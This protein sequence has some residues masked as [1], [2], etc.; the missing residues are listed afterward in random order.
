MEV[1]LKMKFHQELNPKL[2]NNFE[3]KEEVKDKLEEITEAFIEYLDIPAESILDVQITG[4]SANYNYTEHSDLDLHLIVDYEKV[5]QE[6][7]IVEG[8]LWSMKSAFNKEHDISI[9][10]VPVEVYAEDS[11]QSAVSNGVYSLLNDEWIKKPEKIEPTT[12][13]AAVL[14]KYNEIKDIVDKLNDSEEAEEILNKVYEMRKAGLAQA[15]EFSTENL[16]FKMLRNEGYIDML[17]KIKKEKIDKQLTLESYNESVKSNKLKNEIENK[18]KQFFKNDKDALD[19]AVVEVT[20]HPDEIRVEV[21]VE[22]DYNGM[23]NLSDRLN[24]IVSKYDKYAYFDFDQ[25]G[26]MV[27]TIEKNNATNKWE[28]IK[29]DYNIGDK[30]TVNNKEGVID[31]LFKLQDDNSLLGVWIKFRDGVKYYT[32]K[33]LD[34]RKNES[35]KEDYEW[36][37]PIARVTFDN[38]EVMET[39]INGTDEE[40]KSYYIG[41]TF[42]LGTEKD[43]MHKVVNVE[44]IRESYKTIKQV[45]TI[46]EQLLEA[47]NLE[48]F[49]TLAY[50]KDEH[51]ALLVYQIGNKFVVMWQDDAEGYPDTSVDLVLYDTIPEAEKGFFQ[52]DYVRNVDSFEDFTKNIRIA[53]PLFKRRAKDYFQR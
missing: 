43:D 6:C 47:Q 26:I 19:W 24:P 18:I 21:R 12:N 33:E 2:W 38:G 15:G 39:A 1:G 37:G 27:A 50:S 29:E 44:V 16:A 8:Y 17:K 28:S 5:H 36:K 14:A 52:T 46:I 40:I 48:P 7:P 10:G 42:N 51:N 34:G 31:S 9:Y 23:W 3:L 35:I 22:L 11:R 53:D 45:N 4:S 41:K 25:P 32:T 30:I 49:K 13:D 20:E